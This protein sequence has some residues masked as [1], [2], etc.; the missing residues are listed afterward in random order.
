M[1]KNTK[2]L[3]RNEI[4]LAIGTAVVT[5]ATIASVFTHQTPMPKNQS[6][7]VKDIN[8]LFEHENKVVHPHE[9]Y[10]VRGRYETS[11]GAG[12]V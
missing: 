12:A 2:T 1:Q 6:F 5:L 10:I 7:T 11:I 3:K 9:K 8:K 4:A